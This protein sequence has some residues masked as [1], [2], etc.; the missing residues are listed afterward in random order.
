[1]RFRR[2]TI[3][4]LEELKDEFIQFL[5]AN[6]ITGDDWTKLKEE[7]N[8]KAEKLID[9]FSEIVMEKSLSNVRFLEKRE[10][11]NLLLFHAR[12]EE[13]DL[14]GLSIDS[15][16]YD[17]TNPDDIKE[18]MSDPSKV[19]LQMFR[20]SKPYTKAREEEVFELLETGCQVTDNTLFAA[21]SNV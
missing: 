7:E 4:E 11:K 19:N 9:I 16:Q 12:A 6:T 14:I 15:D 2:L 21:L 17:F 8:E 3:E 10:P 1:M 13:I 18:L 5:A 20:S